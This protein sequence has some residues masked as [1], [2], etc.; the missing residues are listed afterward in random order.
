[1][2]LLER[3]PFLDALGDYATEAGSGNGRLVVVTGEAGIGKTSLI[4]A[5]RARRPD[6]RW[7]WGACDGGFTPRPLGPLYDI[8]ASAGGRLRDLVSPGNDRNEMFAGVLAELREAGP[9]GVV[10]EDL[11]WADEAT[12]DWLSY[13]SRRVGT[14]PV[15]VL[16]TSRDDEPGDEGVLADVMGRLATHGSTRRIR[17]P[18]LTA[19]ALKH[20]AGAQHAEELHA[21]TGG[22][23]FYVGE[24]LAMGTTEVPPSVADVVRAR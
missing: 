13:L 7:L 6:I 8:A 21:L 4:D 14:L 20:L 23:P 12:L 15:L 1:M 2:E 3:E 5:F 22:N 10:I 18:R 9:T 19:N 24:V 17:L 16:A 11:H